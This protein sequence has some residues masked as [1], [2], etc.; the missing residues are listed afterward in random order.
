MI[1]Y[2]VRCIMPETKPD[3]HID[4][5]VPQFRSWGALERV[6]PMRPDCEEHLEQE[7]VGDTLLIA[8][9]CAAVLAAHLTELAGPEG[10]RG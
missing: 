6:S 2:C 8:I 9:T 1:R 4:A 10:H 5:R 7:L 3:L